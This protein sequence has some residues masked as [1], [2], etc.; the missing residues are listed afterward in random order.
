MCDFDSINPEI[1]TEF[2]CNLFTNYIFKYRFICED[3]NDF[4]AEIL[5]EKSVI[6]KEGIAF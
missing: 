3:S 5:C 4:L 6:G 1:R 2:Y